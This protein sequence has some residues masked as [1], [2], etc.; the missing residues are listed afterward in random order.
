VTTP[1]GLIWIT[2][3]S[4][5]I[6]RALALRMARDGWRVAASA[7]RADELAELAREAGGLP[8]TIHAY[9]LDVTDQAA[10]WEAVATIEHELG[11]IDVSVLNAGTHEPTPAATFAAATLRRLLEVNVI[12]VANGLEAVLPRLIA[13]RTGRV[14]IVASVAGYG[15]LPNA[16]A[17]GAT[18]AALINLAEAMRPELLQRGVILQVIN[19]GFVKTP[20]TDKNDFAMPF[21]ISAED[22][23]EVIRRG[24]QSDR[25][26]I[27]FPTLFVRLM[28]LVRVLPYRLYFRLT[29]KLVRR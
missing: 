19:P 16:A 8:G 18:K 15:G 25:F 21:L 12:G 6:G 29:A 3:A 11:A 24:L 7:R 9:P 14:A 20:L 10:V 13:R 27:A 5:G 2:G 4:A 22:A 28:K 1:P 26:E 17:Y 23:A